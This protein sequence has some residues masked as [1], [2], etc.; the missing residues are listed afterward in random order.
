MGWQCPPPRVE[1]LNFLTQER[2]QAS[3]APRDAQM[4]PVSYEGHS[5]ATSSQLSQK[6]VTSSALG[7][8]S[9]LRARARGVCVCKVE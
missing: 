8:S 7:T 9:R 4:G 3:P 1:G 2:A 6:T 5:P